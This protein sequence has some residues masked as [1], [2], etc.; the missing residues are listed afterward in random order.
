LFDVLTV[1]D[2]GKHRPEFRGL[3]K[4]PLF[5]ERRGN[6]SRNGLEGRRLT[7]EPN[8]EVKLSTK[9]THGKNKE[10]KKRER[11]VMEVDGSEEAAIRFE[12]I[13][14]ASKKERRDTTVSLRGRRTS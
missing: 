13:E 3:E 9:Q 6:F 10:K 2:S 11:T 1:G 8:D 12:D 5:G 7:Q 14:L 4:G